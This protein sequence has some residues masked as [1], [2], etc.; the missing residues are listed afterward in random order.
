MYFYTHTRS[1]KL[2]ID[3]VTKISVGK[4]ILKY[5]TGPFEYYLYAIHSVKL[6]KIVGVMS[7]QCN[8]VPCPPKQKLLPMP[9]M[10]TGWVGGRWEKFVRHVSQKL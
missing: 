5:L 8:L 4:G 3:V 10:V 9:L 6:T 2:R 1:G 7:R